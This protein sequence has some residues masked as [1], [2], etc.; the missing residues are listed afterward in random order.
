[1]AP[2]RAMAALLAC[3]DDTLAL[4]E[5]L[6]ARAGQGDV[7]AL[8]GPLG[9]GKTSLARGLASGLD[10][11]ASA[12]VRSPS[13]TL[14]NEYEGRLPVLHFDLYR[15]GSGEEADDLGFRDR[16]GT[17]VVAIVEWADRFPALLPRHSLWI[18]IEHCGSSRRATAWGSPE[19]GEMAGDLPEEL[20]WSTVDGKAPWVRS[21]SRWC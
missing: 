11:P 3:E 15:L 14:C 7:F 2:P 21:R 6:G 13:F 9:A 16:A 20:A 17:E 5:W 19:G 8:C 4:G 1:M 10:V 18:E 12:A